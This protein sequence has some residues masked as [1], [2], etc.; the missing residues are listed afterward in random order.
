MRHIVALQLLRQ[1]VQL[2]DDTMRLLAPDGS[3]AMPVHDA[4]ILRRRLHF[5][6]EPLEAVS[7]VNMGD[8]FS[9]FSF[10]QGISIKYF[11]VFTEVVDESE[12]NIEG[13]VGCS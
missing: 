5:L 11:L 8:T 1:L 7:P 3:F 2:A 10:L 12:V 13:L 9:I 4:S 6:E